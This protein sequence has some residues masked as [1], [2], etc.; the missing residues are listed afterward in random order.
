M[1]V[2]ALVNSKGKLEDSRIEIKI[3]GS[4]GKLG[5]MAVENLASLIKEFG[6]MKTEEE[7]GSH[8]FMITGYVM[9]C[10]VCG[11]LTAESGKEVIEMI[12]YHVAKER[13]RVAAG[14]KE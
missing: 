7:I 11:F 9:C 2:K 6:E 8:A 5:K 1:I 13:K 12:I 14:G 3:Q 10:I 4:G